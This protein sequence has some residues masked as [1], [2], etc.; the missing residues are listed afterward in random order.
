M[1]PL[2]FI[3]ACWKFMETKRWMWAQ[4]GSGWC[5][6]AVVTAIWKTSHVPDCHD[7]CHTMKWRASQSTHLNI[8]ADLQP[9]NCVTAEYQLQCVGNDIGH[10]GISQNLY[11]VG[12]TNAHT[13]TERLSFAS[14]SG[15]VE[16]MQGWG[17]SLMNLE[18]PSN[19]S[20]SRIPWGWRW[21][22]SGSH[23]YWWWDVVSPL[24]AGVKTVVHGVATLPIEVVN[25]PLKKKFK[26]QNSV[27]KVMCTVL[28]DRKWV[29]LLDLLEPG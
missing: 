10:A 11:Q 12:L 24:Q 16:P 4:W 1:H 15:P 29:I 8:L 17:W 14:L 6:S 27:G 20:H 7:S 3:D 22:F 21:H 25:S 5:V 26:L 23:H 19:P 13:K 18:V 9:G 28:W 2:T